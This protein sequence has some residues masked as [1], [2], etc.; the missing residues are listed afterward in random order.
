MLNL[1][2]VLLQMGGWVACRFTET[3]AAAN[4]N[5][6]CFSD[7]TESVLKPYQFKMKEI[8]GFRYRCRVSVPP[9]PEVVPP[10]GSSD[11]TGIRR[12]SAGRHAVGHQAGG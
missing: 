10:R 3:D 4:Q 8:E 9:R 1:N 12:V 6:V 11:L 2:V 7:N 5:A